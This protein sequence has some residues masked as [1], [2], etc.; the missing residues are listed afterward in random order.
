MAKSAA[1]I[2]AENS[3]IQV[4]VPA[5]APTNKNER[6]ARCGVWGLRRLGWT[7]RGEFTNTT[8]VLVIVAPHSSNWD[9]IIGVC[10]LWSLQLKFSYLIKDTAFVWP[11]SI[12]L[13]RTGGIAINRAEPGSI[14]EKIV[15]Q[16]AKS[17][18]LYYAITPEG[19]RTE[20]KH[21]K[22][23]FL[24]VVYQASVPLVPVSF[25]Y[26]KKEILIAP[27]FEL[28]GVIDDDMK[29]IRQYFRVFKGRKQ[30]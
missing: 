6:L 5:K 19:T 29:S 12:L 14:V 3:P 9:W 13:R 20:V 28:S 16:F 8:K 27:P 17:E 1:P 7:V 2:I 26:A 4:V 30:V 23:G 22:T 21:W 18:Q 15:E 10:A 11:L 25:D 24:R